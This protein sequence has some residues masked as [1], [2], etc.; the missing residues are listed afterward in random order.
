MD[1][2]FSRPILC[3][4]AGMRKAY[5]GLPS[6]SLKNLT[7]HFHISMDRHHRAM[8]DAKAAAQLLNLMNAKRESKEALDSGS[9]AGDS[10]QNHQHQNC[11]KDGADETRRLANLI[12]AKNLTQI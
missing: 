2:Y 10:F 8:S 1:L 11:S 3:T 4:C 12:D 5:P 6:Y 9:T 7:D